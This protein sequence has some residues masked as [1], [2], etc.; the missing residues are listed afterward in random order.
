MT[1]NNLQEFRLNFCKMAAAHGLK[2]SELLA[3]IK[4]AK[5]QNTK[6]ADW[7]SIGETTGKLVKDGSLLALLAALTGGAALGGITAYG[8]NKA[9]NTIDPSGDL[10]GDEE[11]PI[12]DAKKLQ[13]IAKYR[14]A[15]DRLNSFNN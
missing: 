7:K 8:L 3:Y 6:V 1:D 11:D 5:A 12:S 14:S 15:T 4:Y 2:P 13:L 10:L 9:E